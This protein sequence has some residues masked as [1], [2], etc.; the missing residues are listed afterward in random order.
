MA[1]NCL[2]ESIALNNSITFSEMFRFAAVGLE[3]GAYKN[4]SEIGLEMIEI[5]ALAKAMCRRTM[6]VCQ[7]IT[8]EV[9]ATCTII[10]V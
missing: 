4:H 10:W 6:C 2:L 3:N 1:S 5:S 7:G 9:G 8:D